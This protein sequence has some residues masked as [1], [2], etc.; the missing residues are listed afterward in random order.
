MTKLCGICKKASGVNDTNTE[1][2]EQVKAAPVIQLLPQ[3]T[4]VINY[5]LQQNR[6]PILPQVTIQNHTDTMLSGFE[7]RTDYIQDYDTPQHTYPLGSLAFG[8][9]DLD[10]ALYP[11]RGRTLPERFRVVKFLDNQTM[12]QSP[13]APDTC[14]YYQATSFYHD[15]AA[16]VRQVSPSLFDP[17][18]DSTCQLAS[19]AI[20]GS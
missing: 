7:G 9:L 8:V 16:A 12:Q 2:A 5:A 1:Q 15:F 18:E 10:A 13:A 19:A 4:P 20:S 17:M 11:E 14:V 6:L 3:L